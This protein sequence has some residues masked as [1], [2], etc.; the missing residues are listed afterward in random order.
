M[1]VPTRQALLKDVLRYYTETISPTKKS[2]K[3]E[4]YR[5]KA[6]S[7]ILGNF[8][9]DEIVPVHVVTFRDR[10]MATVHPRDGSKTLSA[11]TVKLEL[12]LLSHVFSTAISE[13]GMDDLVNPVLKVRK[14]KTPSGRTRRL[15]GV[16]EKLVLRAA[17]RHPNREFYAIVV[18]AL[19]TAMRQGELLALA[20]ENISWDKRTALLPITK[21]GDVR[22]VPLS[23]KAY[24]ILRNW[25]VPK[26]EGR[27]FSYTTSGIKSSWKSFTAGLKLE[28]FHF[29]DL[30]HCAISSLVEKGLSS[31]EVASISGHKSMSMLKRYSHLYAY[32]LVEKLDPKP[33]ARRNRAVLRSQLNAYP[34]IVLKKSREI[35]IDFVDFID[36][37]VRVDLKVDAFEKAQATLLATLVTK[38]CDG[39]DVPPPSSREEAMKR[40]PKSEIRMI[41]P[42]G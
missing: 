38:L 29:H 31:I 16:E 10:R 6:L 23:Q 25:L 18:L 11:A 41:S 1:F 27:V 36:L 21:N 24:E 13:W 4:V 35:E 19:E 7:E 33:K 32:K 26:N 37:R 40:F 34:A 20:W 14:P 2:Y 9:F 12:M 39:V 22:E 42:L 8:R 17:L 30:R 15:T 28:N 3:T 5:I